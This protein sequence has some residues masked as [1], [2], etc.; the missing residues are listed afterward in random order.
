[1]KMLQKNSQQLFSTS[2]WQISCHTSKYQ[3]GLILDCVK[4]CRSGKLEINTCRKSVFLLEAD[5]KSNNSR[6]WAAQVQALYQPMIQQFTVQLH[7]LEQKVL[8]IFSLIS[9]KKRLTGELVVLHLLFLHRLSLQWPVTFLK[10]SRLVYANN[11][12]ISSHLREG[13]FVKWLCSLESRKECPEI[14]LLL[15][16]LLEAFSE[17]VGV[18]HRECQLVE[19]VLRV[20][21]HK[22]YET[23]QRAKSTA[24]S[25]H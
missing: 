10:E 24:Q 22:I 8:T 3:V 5:Q 7:R 6:N 14:H 17:L 2:S 1:M 15:Y 4:V 20:L 19:R 16:L 18:F 12:D 11:G 23:R 13:M 25:V 21:L 9:N